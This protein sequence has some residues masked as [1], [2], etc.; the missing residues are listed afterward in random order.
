MEKVGAERNAHVLGTEKARRR[1]EVP[2]PGKSQGRPVGSVIFVA[3][4]VQI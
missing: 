2:C 4:L 1:L 3:L